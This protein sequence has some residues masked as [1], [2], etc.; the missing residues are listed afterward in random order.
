[1]YAPRI[2]LDSRAEREEYERLYRHPAR[3]LQDRMARRG[4]TDRTRKHAI[5]EWETV[6]QAEAQERKLLHQ[7]R[8]LNWGKEKRYYLAQKGSA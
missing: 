7:A 3:A 2:R 4:H 8:V 5:P 1:M 6:Y